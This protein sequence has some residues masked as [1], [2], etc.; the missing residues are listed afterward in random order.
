MQCMIAS[1]NAQHGGTQQYSK[2]VVEGGGLE[3]RHAKH[4]PIMPHLLL[5][6]PAGVACMA[7]LGKV[8]VW[9]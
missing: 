2:I 7:V 5:M 6:Q 8:R 9:S 3:S 1:T 4:N